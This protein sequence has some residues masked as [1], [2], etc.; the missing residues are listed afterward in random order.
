MKYKYIVR[1]ALLIGLIAGISGSCK[2]RNPGEGKDSLV[3]ELQAQAN[4]DKANPAPAEVEIFTEDYVVPPGIK[5]QPT[6]I[7]TGAVRL[8][9]EA[10]LKN[11][12][13]LKAS[14]L[15]KA[16]EARPLGNYEIGVFVFSLVPVEGGYIL[17]NETGMWLLDQQLNKQRM[18]FRNEVNVN[19][20]SKSITINHSQIRMVFDPYVDASAGIVRAAYTDCIIDK[21]KI[22]HAIV[23]FTLQELLAAPQPLTP[24]DIRSC[25][26]VDMAVKVPTESGVICM[27]GGY[28]QHVSFSNDLYTFNP[29]GDTL[30]HFTIGRPIDYTP[31]GS[32]RSEDANVYYYQGKLI[33]RLP[34]NNTFYRMKDAST[35]EAVYVLDFGSLSQADA[36]RTVRGSNVDNG[37]FIE[38]WLETDTYVFVR[39]TQGYY[40]KLAV[41][42]G[43]VRLYSL[44]YNKQTKEFFSLP[45]IKPDVYPFIEAD[46]PDSFPFWPDY[47]FEG[48]PVLILTDQLQFTH[49]DWNQRA[50]HL[51]A[52]DEGETV[53]VTIK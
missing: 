34:F 18:L 43:K 29:K 45:S 6:I 39:I 17:S 33:F 24:D 41:K 31:K 19:R 48:R 2:P 4:Q 23:S 16:F 10:A 5:Y 14:D 51:S 11:V 32:Y 21:T 49:F 47:C 30:C 52:L 28:A 20:T 42:D 12:R 1:N 37:Y 35:L 7:Q 53:F 27:D 40:S 15:G 22:T 3:Q 46:L 9:V 36:D 8:D 44:V 13:P 26:P 25:L 38:S 50:S